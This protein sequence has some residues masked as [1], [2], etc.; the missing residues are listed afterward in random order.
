MKLARV[1]VLKSGKSFVEI[2]DNLFDEW[3]WG[4]DFDSQKDAI[5]YSKSQH[6][7]FTLVNHEKD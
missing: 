1:T 5:N 2:K 6:C 4:N 3:H 7:I